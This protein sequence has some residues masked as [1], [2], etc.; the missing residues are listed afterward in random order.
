MFISTLLVGFR[1]YMAVAA[2]NATTIEYHL[3]GNM[4]LASVH[5]HSEHLYCCLCRKKGFLWICYSGS[6]CVYRAV[7]R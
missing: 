7:E 4:L 1:S 2:F 6:V 5:L 3:A